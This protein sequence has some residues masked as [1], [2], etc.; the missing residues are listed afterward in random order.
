[1][2]LRIRKLSQLWDKGSNS[3]CL[4]QLWDKSSNSTFWTEMETRVDGQRWKQRFLFKISQLLDK[5]DNSRFFNNDTPSTKEPVSLS[6]KQA[7]FQEIQLLV[8][9]IVQ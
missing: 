8:K 3:M 1:M 4:S 6:F 2:Y 9:N 7:L 5:G